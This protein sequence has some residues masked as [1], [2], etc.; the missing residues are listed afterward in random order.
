MRCYKVS[1]IYI[2][3]LKLWLIMWYWLNVEILCQWCNGHKNYNKDTLKDDFGNNRYSMC[4]FR[5]YKWLDLSK[6]IL[7]YFV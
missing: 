3:W 7:M 2:I 6:I 1:D 5:M 4:T